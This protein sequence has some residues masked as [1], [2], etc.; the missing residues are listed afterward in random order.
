MR[1]A[2]TQ[3]AQIFRVVFAPTN[4]KA[5]RTMEDLSKASFVLHLVLQRL[6]VVENFELPQ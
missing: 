6:L 2:F 1:G 4:S 3:V 5:R